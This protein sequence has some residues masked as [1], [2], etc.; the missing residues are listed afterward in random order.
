M[1]RKTERNRF[2][3]DLGNKKRLILD[4]AKL[5]TTD[6]DGF[7]K[8]VLLWRDH[9]LNGRVKESRRPGFAIRSGLLRNKA[10]GLLHPKYSVL[11]QDDA[12]EDFHAL[13]IFLEF[14]VARS[15]LPGR[16]QDVETA[17]TVALDGWGDL[18]LSDHARELF[19][20]R[21]WSVPFYVSAVIGD[22]P[23]AKTWVDE[24]CDQTQR[25]KVIT[26]LARQRII[27]SAFDIHRVAAL[28][29]A[30][31]KDFKPW[32]AYKLLKT[33]TSNE[34]ANLVKTL[35]GHIERI[36]DNYG[37]GKK[38]G[39]KAPD[40][41]GPLPFHLKFAKTI[42]LHIEN[43]F[44][45]SAKIAIERSIPHIRKRSKQIADKTEQVRLDPKRNDQEDLF[46]RYFGIYATAALHIT[47][48]RFAEERSRMIAIINDPSTDSDVFVSARP[49]A[50]HS[51]KAHQADMRNLVEAYRP[52]VLSDV[53]ASTF[54]QYSNSS[55]KDAESNALAFLVKFQ[56]EPVSQQTRDTFEMLDLSHWARAGSS[57][58]K[59]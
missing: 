54:G 51:F 48:Y 10:M 32:F 58:V 26:I 21:Q 15:E 34:L 27:W 16:F 47:S 35:N 4:A 56:N 41:K 44:S 36:F 2:N 31:I 1:K 9:H 7:L 18:S 12:P 49:K 42:A 39:R 3:S 43:V 11:T 59:R 23:S 24:I 17:R 28:G 33:G 55:M 22:F 25:R 20:L 40:L 37:I 30:T 5:I 13:T 45:D 38:Y 57:K 6:Y 19:A 29:F 52:A 14:L 50:P 46:S 53:N 8:R